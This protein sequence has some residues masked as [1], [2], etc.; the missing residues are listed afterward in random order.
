MARQVGNGVPFIE[1]VELYLSQEK[2]MNEQELLNSLALEKERKLK[3]VYALEAAIKT[4][5]EYLDGCDI[6]YPPA[7]VEP[8]T[9]SAGVMEPYYAVAPAVGGQTYSVKIKL[10]RQKGSKNKKRKWTSKKK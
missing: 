1:M 8:K 10:G 5:E 6:K 4:V 7:F 2:K 3:E 9:E